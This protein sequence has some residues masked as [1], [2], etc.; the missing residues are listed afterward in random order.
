M[1]ESCVGKNPMKKIIFVKYYI[2]N[3]YIKKRWRVHWK[4]IFFENDFNDEGRS[5]RKVVRNLPL[6]LG[7][8]HEVFWGLGPLRVLRGH[9]SPFLLRRNPVSIRGPVACVLRWPRS[10][11]LLGENHE[12]IA[13]LRRQIAVQSRLIIKCS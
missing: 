3:L 12:S 9:K 5:S 1:V 6:L 8:N 13:Y 2:E 4:K 11:F 10:P 7:E